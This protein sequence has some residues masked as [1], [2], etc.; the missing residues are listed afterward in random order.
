MEKATMLPVRRPRR[1]LAVRRRAAAAAAAI[2]H[3]AQAAAAA[4]SGSSSHKRVISLS[5]LT[6]PWCIRW[7][8]PLRGC[9][10]SRK[11]LFARRAVGGQRSGP[12]QGRQA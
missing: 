11:K 9:V 12:A 10:T 5:S 2:S 4:G 3:R 8:E 1:R 6:H 7:T